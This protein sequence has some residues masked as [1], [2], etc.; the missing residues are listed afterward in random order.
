MTN[1]KLRSLFDAVFLKRLPD[2]DTLVRGYLQ[3]TPD[4]PASTK[5]RDDM[6]KMLAEK[7]Y[8][9]RTSRGAYLESVR[10]NRLFLERYSY[11]FAHPGEQACLLRRHEAVGVGLC[12]VHLRDTYVNGDRADRQPDRSGVRV[13]SSARRR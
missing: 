10:D 7:G 8:D 6:R 11:L 2:W 13:S 4:T 5:W 12:R 3:I 9:R 1:A